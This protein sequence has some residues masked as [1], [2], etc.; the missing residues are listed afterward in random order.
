M[1]SWVK[2]ALRFKSAIFRQ[3]FSLKS[4]YG[5]RHFSPFFRQQQSA[6]FR[7][8]SLREKKVPFFANN[9]AQFFAAFRS[10]KKSAL[11]REKNREKQARPNSQPKTGPFF[12]AFRTAKSTIFRHFSLREK[13]AIFRRISLREKKCHFREKFREKQ[14]RPKRPGVVRVL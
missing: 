3:F 1:Q 8:I 4:S 2:P 7:R 9:K 5:K 13:S 6:I 14:A 11:F 12:A 10:A